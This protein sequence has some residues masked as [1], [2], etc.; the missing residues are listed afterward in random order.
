MKKYWVGLVAGLVLLLPAGS[1]VMASVLFYDPLAGQPRDINLYVPA[2]V[3]APNTAT[4]L[5]AKVRGSWDREARLL[6]GDELRLQVDGG[7]GQVDSLSDGSY[8]MSGASDH[9]TMD[10]I[11]YANTGGGMI[12][13]WYMAIDGSNFATVEIAAYGSV[14][15]KGYVDTGWYTAKFYAPAQ[16]NT[17]QMANLRVTDL[18]AAEQPSSRVSFQVSMDLPTADLAE[19]TGLQS[20]YNISRTGGMSTIIFATDTHGFGIGCGPMSAMNGETPE[21][22]GCTDARNGYAVSAEQSLALNQVTATTPAV[23]ALHYDADQYLDR[24][25]TWSNLVPLSRGAGTVDV[26]EHK[27]L[28][29]LGGGAYIAL[30][31][32]NLPE[33]VTGDVGEGYISANSPSGGAGMIIQVN[34]IPPTFYRA[35][36]Y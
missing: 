31:R 12:K 16:I 34:I 29:N 6:T 33:G 9:V 3:V 13:D 7:D 14:C 10:H 4:T 1:W 11:C 22:S 15:P 30:S 18:T 23:S 5:I 32:A 19:L 8:S 20:A 17:A 28:T 26:G 36:L 35:F 21:A 2:R 27:I 25:I 24:R